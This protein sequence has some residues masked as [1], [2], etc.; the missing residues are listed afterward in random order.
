M[1]LS[2]PERR[3]RQDTLRQQRQITRIREELRS[4]ET[5]K[6]VQFDPVPA[7]TKSDVDSDDDSQPDDSGDDAFFESGGGG[8]ADEDLWADHP[9]QQLNHPTSP[10]PVE[11]TEEASVEAPEEAP[12]EVDDG[13]GRRADGR[14][15]RPRN[16][17]NYKEGR[18][19]RLFA[20][21][22][23]APGVRRLSAKQIRYR[24]RLTA[25]RQVGNEMLAKTLMA[26]LLFKFIRFAANDSK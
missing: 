8:A 7:L 24:K 9:I 6:K 10:E 20:Q 4:R 14:I 12:E 5:K 3:D 19:A 13:L 23:I 17:P 16:I 22:A 1:W 18:R 11:P 25:R 21:M 2:E 15:R 26:S